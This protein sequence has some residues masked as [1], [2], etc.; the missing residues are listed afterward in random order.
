MEL[1]GLYDPLNVYRT[2]ETIDNVSRRMTWRLL[3]WVEEEKFPPGDRIFSS[4]DCFSLMEVDIRVDL[5][6]RS[7][8]LRD[9]ERKR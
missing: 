4:S 2:G 8:L 5:S 9:E 6:G 1:I 3:V 7:M